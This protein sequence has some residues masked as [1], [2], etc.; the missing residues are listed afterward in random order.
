VNYGSSVAIANRS[1]AAADDRYMLNSQLSDGEDVAIQSDVKP[2]A[3]EDE[4]E[5]TTKRYATKDYGWLGFRNRSSSVH[6]LR[7]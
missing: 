5:T 7:S 3:S 2:R 6:I 4:T 1:A